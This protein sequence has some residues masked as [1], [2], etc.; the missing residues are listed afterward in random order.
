MADVKVFHVV[1]A[2]HVVVD[3]TFTRA[4]ERLDGVHLALLQSDTRVN[5]NKIEVKPRVLFSFFLQRLVFLLFRNSDIA[6]ESHAV[7]ELIKM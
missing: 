7:S 2:L 5:E 3:H 1:R 6:L 4:A